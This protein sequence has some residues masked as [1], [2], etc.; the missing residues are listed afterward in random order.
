MKR[1]ILALTLLASGCTEEFAKI[2]SDHDAKLPYD[3]EPFCLEGTSYWRYQQGGGSWHI[4]PRLV[5]GKVV[6]CK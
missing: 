2:Q 6:T 3:M 4:T 1:L 5:N